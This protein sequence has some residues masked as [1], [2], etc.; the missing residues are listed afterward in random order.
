MV[1]THSAAL[2][3][4]VRLIANHGQERKYYHTRIGYNY[5]MTDI[6]AALGIVQLGKVQAF[7]A[8]RQQNAAY[9][10]A[11]LP[12]EGIIPPAVSRGSTHVYHQYVIRVTDGFPMGRDALIDHLAGK[13]IGSAVHYPVP[14]HR[15]PVYAR[16][17]T[18]CSCPVSEEAACEVL[19]LP[20]HPK[21]GQEDLAYMCRVIREV[22]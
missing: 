7:N 10:T 13:G 12:R 5:R 18:E 14:L 22:A 21:V 19:S 15:Q 2:A 17:K 1:T 16:D 11:H 20:V 3:D 9:L 6:A 4:T 8:A